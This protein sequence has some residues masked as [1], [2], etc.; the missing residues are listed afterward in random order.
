MEM[1][2]AESLYIYNPNRSLAAG[3]EICG[4]D[5]VW[6]PAKIENLNGDRGLINGARLV[7]S[8]EGV[9]EP[10]KLRYLHSKPWFG[11]IYNEVNLPLGA[12][13]LE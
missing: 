2:N 13:T 8:A 11:C 7:V 1:E 9:A 4:A 10:A 6:H 5:G 12:F 3:L